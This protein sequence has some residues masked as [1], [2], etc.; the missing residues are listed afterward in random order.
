MKPKQIAEKQ[1]QIYKLL[2]ERRLKEAFALLRELAVESNSWQ[3]SEQLNQLETSY[4]YMI[5]YMLD[6]FHDPERTSIYNQL[7]L[8][9][10]SLVDT[11]ADAL[12]ELEASTLY[13]SRRRYT[14]TLSNHS[15]EV[16]FNRFDQD[17]NKY[18]IEQLLQEQ[19][20]SRLQSSDPIR[21][22]ESDSSELF[23]EIWTNSPATAA[24]YTALDRALTEYHLPWQTLA[25]VVSAVTLNLLHSYDERK[26]LWLL[27]C[28]HHSS[29][30]VNQR[31]LCGALLVI[32]MN[33]ERIALSPL[34]KDRLEALKVQPNFCKDAR[35]LF[36]QFIQSRE[37]ERIAHKLNNEVWP[38]MIKLNPSLYQK[39]REEES[40]SEQDLSASERNPE[41]QEVF[42]QSGLADKLKE[43]SD[44][45]LEGADVFMGT[46]ATLKSFPFFGDIANWFLPFST[47]HTALASLF[48]TE[49]GDS[50]FKKIILNSHFLCN[51]DKYSFCLSLTQIPESHRQMM[52]QQFEVDGMD[53]QQ[54]QHDDNQLEP[55]LPHDKVSNQYVQDLYRF[56]KLFPRRGEFADPF[57]QSLNLYQV[58]ELQSIFSDEESLRL[59]GEYYFRKEYYPEALAFFDRLALNHSDSELYQKVGYCYQMMGQ[60]EESL[61]A[62]LKADIIQPNHYWTIMR[63]ATTYRN[64]KMSDMALLYYTK[65]E[66]LKPNNLSVQL[67]IGHCHLAQKNYAEALTYYF[68]VEY[69]AP[70][71]R[72]AW[73]PIAWCSFL[74]GKGEQ[75]MRYYDK[76]LADTP[77]SL[78]Y[79]NAA[80]VQF[81]LGNIK[82]AITLYRQSLGRESEDEEFMRTFEQD[83]PDLIA[84][85]VSPTD[86]PILLDQ[87]MY[88]VS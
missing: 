77:T 22:L 79:M 13:Y 52:T 21:T 41:W 87:L 80:H 60:H 3:C 55:D 48:G 84:A 27:Q 82:Q 15:L 74:V 36:L 64:L 76:L 72:K 26:L 8:S 19:S 47:H 20:L 46:F 63:I 49:G 85:G 9:A 51:S 54:L 32:Y 16:A 44:L 2:S 29:V 57:E 88:G 62:Y 83:T 58:E 30:E 7:V 24:D 6:G 5:Q 28:Y 56:F 17:L 37:T 50:A 25:L 35:N 86:I 31:A 18:S 23:A 38:D 4:R 75:A 14:H 81:A 40:E 66:G 67:N 10:Y 53:L 71:S 11:L 59:I 69:L 12:M 34:V 68:K 43:L 33:R 70:N 39:I 45:H 73:R 65:A 61:E 42:E 1:T 78:D